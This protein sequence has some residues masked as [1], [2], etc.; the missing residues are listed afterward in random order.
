MTIDLQGPVDAALARARPR[1]GLLVVGATDG[2]RTAS[3]SR[4]PLPGPTLAAERAVFEIGS[5]T[6]VFTSLLFA[7]AVGRAEVGLDDPVVEHL[8]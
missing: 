1:P 6:K 3:A 2:D 8:P 7:I 5:I 4:G